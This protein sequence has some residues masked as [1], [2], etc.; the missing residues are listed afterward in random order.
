MSPFNNDWP[1][2][3]F[4]SQDRIAIDSVAFDFLYNEWHTHPH[5]PGAHDY[6][7]EAALIPEPPSGVNYDPNNDGGLT[8]SLGVHEHWNN[9]VDKQYSRNLDPINGAGIELVTEPSL[10]GDFYRD[11]VVNFKDFAVLAA[12]WASRPGDVN[13]KGACDISMPSD[14]VID[15]NDFAVFHEN[16]LK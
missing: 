15:E 1:S 2:S 13:W 6:L 7:H 9:P 4:L 8:E 11:G 5:M 16:W 14:G 12:A 10:I 3:I